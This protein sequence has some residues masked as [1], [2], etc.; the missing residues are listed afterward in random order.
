MSNL[1]Y[2]L[3]GIARMLLPRSLFQAHLSSKIAHYFST[4][5]NAT[6]ELILKRVHH[7]CKINTPFRLN[8]PNFLANSLGKS[9]AKPRLSLQTPNIAFLGQNNLSSNH[10]TVY[11]YDSYQWSRYFA[12]NLIWAYC[13]G[14]VNYY[15]DTPAITKTRPIDSVLESKVD[16]AQESLEAKSVNAKSLNW[17]GAVNKKSSANSILLQLDKN[18]HFCFF[19]DNIAYSDKQDKL[20]FRGACYQEH[21][22]RFLK[23]Y[24]NHPKCD[25]ADTSDKKHNADFIGAKLSKQE[26]C[27]YKFILSLE[28]NDV[29]SNL[30]WVMNSNSLCVMPKPNYESWFMESKLQAGVHYAEINDDYSNVES[31]LD[32]YL[33]HK[34]EAQEIIK[35]A[36]QYCKN[37]Q[38]PTI[39]EACNILVLRKYFYLSGQIEISDN[40]KALFGL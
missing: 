40:E 39:E 38:N 17:G 22:N 2:N 35:N 1:S 29:A 24:F 7:Y 28:G 20:I 4:F 8:P 34:S 6:L 19:K 12:D 30:K 23:M 11:Y 32:Y 13:F 36:Q 21:R 5:D 9:E 26:H 15:L 16:L 37:F 14:D 3:K 18:R 25:I 10:S 33:N 27:K 31:V